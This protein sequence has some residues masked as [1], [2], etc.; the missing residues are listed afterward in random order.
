[1]DKEPESNRGKARRLKF[2]ER[3]V[4]A[5][6][7]P[8]GAAEE[9]VW[10]LEQRGLCVRVRSTGAASYYVTYRLAGKLRWYRIG[11]RDEKTL[12]DARAT[13]A[14]ARILAKEGRD[15]AVERA[16]AARALTPSEEATVTGVANAWLKSTAGRKKES[17]RKI[18]KLFIDRFIGPALGDRPAA[19]VTYSE[20]EALHRKITDGRTKPKRKAQGSGSRGGKAGGS[21]VMANRIRACLSAIMTH[22]EKQGLRPHGSNPC[23]GVTPNREL[24]RHRAL[25]E[26]ELRRLAKSLNEW[27]T[28]PHEV[29][30][31]ETGARKRHTRHDPSPTEAESAARRR[32]ADCI[33]TI[34]LTGCR[35]SEIAH[36]RWSE[37]DEEHKVLR[38]ADSKT[39]PRAVPLNAFALAVIKRQPQTPL[40]PFVFA[41]SSK[42]G[43]PLSD[44]KRAW[45]AIKTRAGLGTFRTHDLRHHC[46]ETLASMGFSEIVIAKVLGHSKGSTTWGYVAIRDDVLREAVERYGQEIGRALCEQPASVPHVGGERR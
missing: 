10:D 27:P 13:A 5:L 11:A 30:T 3:R 24:P 42:D 18:D 23:R 2:T 8:Q 39:G 4:E 35:R 19:A 7:C 25:S 34:L 37:V 17:T 45:N 40:N 14:E 32:A 16:E 29:T 38:L 31:D 41:S 26:L 15:I 43:S 46:G 1:M 21:P 6:R 28:S 12:A 20:V 44:L 36:L 33:K 22:A 9:V